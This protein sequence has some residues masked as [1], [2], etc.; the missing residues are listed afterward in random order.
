MQYIFFGWCSPRTFPGTCCA[1]LSN[2]LCATP[3]T[4]PLERRH[5]PAMPPSGAASRGLGPRVAPGRR[6]KCGP[7]TT[8]VRLPPTDVLGDGDL[9]VRGERSEQDLRHVLLAQG[10]QEQR[11]AL[12]G[13]V[14][15]A[16]LGTKE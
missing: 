11:Q 13:R 4:R 12:I 16:A 15:A 1:C 14:H 10:H 8:T 7:V 5:L 9:R 3:R 6:P 2:I